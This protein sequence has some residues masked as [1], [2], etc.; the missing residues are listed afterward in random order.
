VTADPIA[1]I[2]EEIAIDERGPVAT[3]RL[4]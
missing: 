3:R 4:G 2:A 1:F